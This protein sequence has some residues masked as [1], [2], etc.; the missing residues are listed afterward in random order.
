MTCGMTEGVLAILMQGTSR[1]APELHPIGPR[2]RQGADPNRPRP[3][4][5]RDGLGGT[6]AP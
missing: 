5:R 1:F 6:T 4:T 2:G 3:A